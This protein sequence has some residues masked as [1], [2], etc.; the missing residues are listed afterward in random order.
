MG[1]LWGLS[2]RLTTLL[3]LNYN[4]TAILLGTFTKTKVQRQLSEREPWESLQ[5]AT[6]TRKKKKKANLITSL[7]GLYY[8]NSGQWPI[9]PVLMLSLIFQS[10]YNYYLFRIYNNKMNTGWRDA[11]FTITGISI[12]FETF[13]IYYIYTRLIVYNMLILYFF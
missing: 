3:S 4:N 5:R 12:Y 1:Y 9:H 10:I 2:K 6:V 11:E 13:Y 8:F 7:F